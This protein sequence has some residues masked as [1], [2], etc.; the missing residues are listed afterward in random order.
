MATG[1]ALNSR[2]HRAEADD[3]LA[4]HVIAVGDHSKAQAA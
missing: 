3:A 1:R 4:L 2:N